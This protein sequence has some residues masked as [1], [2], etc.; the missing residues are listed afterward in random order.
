MQDNFWASLLCCWLL[1][2]A[3]LFPWNAIL[4]IEDYYY[5]VFPVSNANDAFGAC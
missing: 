5:A 1:G 2:T 3:F 4:T